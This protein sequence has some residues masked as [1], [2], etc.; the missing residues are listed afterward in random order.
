MFR[1]TMISNTDI[2]PK[3]GTQN[4]LSNSWQLLI[5]CY[6]VLLKGKMLIH[7]PK[8]MS[9]SHQIKL[10][11]TQPV[12]QPMRLNIELERE[13]HQVLCSVAEIFP[14]STADWIIK[15]TLSHISSDKYKMN[16]WF[17]QSI[18]RLYSPRVTCGANRMSGQE[19]RYQTK[20]EPEKK[21]ISWMSAVVSPATVE[22][23]A[24]VPEQIWPE[25]MTLKDAHNEA[26]I[27]EF[28]K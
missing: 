5:P 19:N 9:R 23:R 22:Q 6:K 24:Y 16:R 28:L 27:R 8:Q 10:L 25:R 14:K 17:Q 20:I 15:T 26:R 7:T 2:S 13:Q 12:N 4:I 1:P 18:A 11:L 21:Y 3:R